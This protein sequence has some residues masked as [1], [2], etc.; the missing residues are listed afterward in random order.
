MYSSERC[1]LVDDDGQWTVGEYGSIWTGQETAGLQVQTPFN[2][3]VR[4]GGD[5][6]RDEERLWSSKG[7]ESDLL[8]W[9][10]ESGALEM[11]KEFIEHQ[12]LRAGD[13][14][15]ESPDSLFVDRLVLRSYGLLEWSIQSGW[16]ATV[17]SLPF[18]GVETEIRKS[19]SICHI[20]TDATTG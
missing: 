3:S 7:E 13:T 19:V 20:P 6:G 14:E 1:G 9:E 17:E 4:A 10:R 2:L 12:P 15:W 18:V 11:G 16:R 5:S 8:E